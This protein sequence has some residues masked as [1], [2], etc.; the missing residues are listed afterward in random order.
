MVGKTARKLD[1]G[2]STGE[3]FFVGDYPKGGSRLMGYKGS[4]IEIPL[5]KSGLNFNPNL[6]EIPKYAFLW[7]TRNLDLHKGRPE[8]RGGTAKVNAT[9]VSGT[10]RVVGLSDFR[11]NSGSSFQVFATSDG[12]VWSSPTAT[13]KTGMSTSNKF[14]FETFDVSN[15]NSLFICDG[16]SRPQV[17]NGA[18]GATSDLTN[19][20]TDWTGSNFP[21]QLIRRQQGLAMVM[22]AVG[23]TTTK[24][25]VYISADND[26]N[27]FS[28]ANV[29]VLVC[30]TG[31][32]YGPVGGIEWGQRLFIFGK[33]EAFYL[34]DVSADDTDWYFVP[35]QFKGGVAHSRLLVASD[36]DLFA[37]MQ[38]GT[39]YSVT[40]AEQFGDYRLAN[41]ARPAFMDAW[42]RENVNLSRIDDFHAVYDPDKRCVMW[43][44]CRTGKTEVDTCLKFYVDR[45]PEDAW[46]IDEQPDYASGYNASASAR[47]Q[48]STGTYKIYTGDYDGHLWTLGESNTTDDGN[49]YYSGFF[50]PYNDFAAPSVNK[51]F[52]RLWA[53]MEPQGNYTIPF[54][55]WVDGQQKASGEFS[56]EGSGT[57]FD[58]SESFETATF[59]GD[60]LIDSAQ[61]L[62]DFGRRVKVEIYNNTAERKF[63]VSSVR[64]DFKPLGAMVQ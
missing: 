40:S 16:S 8:T 11:L 57:L 45:A 38:D 52:P 30:D 25:N 36:N 48:T 46:M 47:V 32:G 59:G 4:S 27:D 29:R 49:P 12:K 62:G 26:P 14:S 17:W 19:I 55:W 64:F 22:V 15:T 51:D 42:I 23:F 37:M 41:I 28:D 6:T 44:V 7:P 9:P 61:E 10:P 58:G 50:L 20:P 53:V 34:N 63:S 3:F 39:I 35:A 24:A 56:V 33:E 43:F 5:G 18:D 21:A 31:D 13:I 54:N 60:E 1:V 2:G